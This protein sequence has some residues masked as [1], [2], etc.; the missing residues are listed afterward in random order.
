[1]WRPTSSKL[2]ANAIPFGVRTIIQYCRVQGHEVASISCWKENISYFNHQ[3]VI[4][5]RDHDNRCQ[6]LAQI[7]AQVQVPLEK[8][9]QNTVCNNIICNNY[10][11]LGSQKK[12]TCAFLLRF[13]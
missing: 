8:K 1:M 11:N 7:I 3:V 6:V 10:S 13:A 9:R 5:C 2:T 12:N 4:T